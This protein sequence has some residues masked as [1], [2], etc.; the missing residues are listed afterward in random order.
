MVLSLFDSLHMAKNLDNLEFSARLRQALSRLPNKVDTSSK[1]ALEFNLV[2]NI[3]VTNQSVHKW[4]TGQSKPTRDKIE[5]LAKMCDV[6]VQWLRYGIAESRP[7]KPGA[8]EKAPTHSTHLSTTEQSLLDNF[9]M[10]PQAQQELVWS[11]AEQL[12]VSLKVWDSD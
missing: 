10:L 5:A 12:A 11:M 1:L 4:L 8:L 7:K 3:P 9:R 6:S 2:H